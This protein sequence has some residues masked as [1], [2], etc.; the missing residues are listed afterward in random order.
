MDINFG[1]T[2]VLVAGGTGGLG[3]A[4]ALA[5]LREGA[6]VAVT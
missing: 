5:F 1:G 4:V 3:S 2:V 6:T